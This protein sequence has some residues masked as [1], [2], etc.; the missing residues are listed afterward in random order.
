MFQVGRAP[1][2]DGWAQTKEGCW[3]SG[4]ALSPLCSAAP[5]ALQAA[6]R[7]GTGSGL[8][9]QVTFV[10][11]FSALCS[12]IHRFRRD[13]LG[14]DRAAAAL[15][16]APPAWGASL[17]HHSVGLVCRQG[18][19]SLLLLSRQL[20]TSQAHTV[21]EH[22]LKSAVTAGLL[23]KH[24]SCCAGC[25][26]V[27]IQRHSLRN[28]PLNKHTQAPGTA[29]AAAVGAGGPSQPSMEKGRWTHWY[30]SQY[31]ADGVLKQ[32]QPAVRFL[33]PP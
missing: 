31:R 7:H 3:G 25:R 15:Q 18:W 24:S 10:S 26:W 27:P 32:G 11:H 8:L 30:P 33:L 9:A 2:G 12:F 28:P 1:C 5:G 22:S 13:L 23:T 21:M 19:A 4:A 16:G 14:R 20:L 29:P 17:G 6:C